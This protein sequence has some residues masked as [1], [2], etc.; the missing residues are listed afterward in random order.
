MAEVAGVVL[1]A[2][3]GKRMGLSFPK[4]LLPVQGKPMLAWVLDLVEK[5]PLAER[6][7]VVGAYPKEIL[8]ALFSVP[9]EGLRGAKIWRVLYNPHWSEGIG[10]SLRCAAEAISTGMLVFLGDMPFVP[11]QAALAV[12]AQAGERALAPSF[13]GQRGFPVY[14]PPS[15]RSALLDLKGD[16]GA[17]YLLGDCELIPWDDPGVVWDVDWPEDLGGEVRCAQSRW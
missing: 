5:L 9:E 10:S 17:R 13:H 8:S 15:L 11:E 14:L 2:G 6:V 7:I 16:V 3:A 4:L 12:L 1:A